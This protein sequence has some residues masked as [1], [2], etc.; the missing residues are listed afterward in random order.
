M[1]LRYRWKG[2]SIPRLAVAVEPRMG[3]VRPGVPVAQRPFLHVVVID[4]MP[5]RTSPATKQSTEVFGPQRIRHLSRASMSL[6]ESP[7]AADQSFVPGQDRR[8]R[9]PTERLTCGGHGPLG[10]TM[11]LFI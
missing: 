5:S 6:S 3:V 9:W 11:L 2:A 7:C 4:R 1:D 10:T 8:C